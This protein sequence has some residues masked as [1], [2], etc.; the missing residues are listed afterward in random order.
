MEA[1]PTFSVLASERPVIPGATALAVSPNGQFL[2][3][4]SKGSLTVFDS[5]AAQIES[6]YADVI[7]FTWLSDAQRIVYASPSKLAVWDFG[8]RMVRDETR[9]TQ[10]L[11]VLSMPTED[12]TLFTPVAGIS[13]NDGRVYVW[14]FDSLDCRPIHD[15]PVARATSLAYSPHGGTLASGHADGSI[16]L[17]KD[18][19]TR[20]LVGPGQD[21]AVTALGWSR[22]GSMLFAGT[23]EGSIGH[24]NDDS[25]D[26]TVTGE[27]ATGVRQIAVVAG[28]QWVVWLTETGEIWRGP[29]GDLDSSVNLNIAD[30]A[31]AFSTVGE[32]PELVILHRDGSPNHLP[33]DDDSHWA[34]AATGTDGTGGGRL[35][36]SPAQSDQASSIDHLGR[37]TLVNA[38]AAMLEDKEQGTPF[39]IGLFGDWGAGKSSVL[40]QLRERLEDQDRD[41][42]LFAE[43]NAWEFEHTDNLAA[44]L[45]QQTIKGLTEGIEGWRLWRLR[46]QFANAV[47]ER[48]LWRALLLVVSG[49]IVIVGVSW[50]TFLFG[51]DWTKTLFGVAGAALIAYAVPGIGRLYDHP[52]SSELRTYLQLPRYGEHLG[53]IPV[54]KSHVEALCDLVLSRSG[55]P[56]RLIV[57]VDDLDRCSPDSIVKIFEAVR[58]V[59]DLQHVVVLLALDGRMALQAVAYEFNDL[60]TEVRSKED[61]ARD[62]L[63]KIIQL[64]IALRRPGADHV[65]D[66]VRAGLFPETPVDEPAAGG[67]DA[68][69]VEGAIERIAAEGSRGP[70]ARLGLVDQGDSGQRTPANSGVAV[71]NDEGTNLEPSR[72]RPKKPGFLK[73]VRNVFRPAPTIAE[74]AA[75]AADRQRSRTARA[76]ADALQRVMAETKTEVEQFIDLATQ[77]QLSN[78]RQLRRL[79]NSYRLLK[80]L[81]PDLQ[82][83]RLMHMLFWQEFLHTLPQSEH[84]ACEAAAVGHVAPPAEIAEDQASMLKAVL[85]LVSDQLASSAEDYGSYRAAVGRLVLPR[86]VPRPL[87]ENEA[88]SESDDVTTPKAKPQRRAQRSRKKSEATKDGADPTTMPN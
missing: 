88:E 16:T 72:N 7:A 6:L 12:Q 78:P 67:D 69:I 23:E 3:I 20:R 19:H 61:I 14:E 80:V 70:D 38:L 75:K 47:Y 26:W 60:A 1:P 40:M 73:F 45:V 74:T 34:G 11:G 58:L 64:P 9:V 87:K 30:P 41:R 5:E 62:Y 29:F 42:F 56:K 27:T 68:G 51:A 15:D 86:P 8:S 24:V 48:E 54:M 25:I 13:D 50:L 53:L 82:S 49:C 32:S 37:D 22:D 71:G 65:A 57:V 63:G 46:W 10:R 77:F 2:T 17:T 36:R 33:F 52:V 66:F 18:R 83:E 84:A 44:G 35:A 76:E 21:I 55:A 81:H 59:M 31:I 39:T 28:D 85:P 79:R 4:L 43:Y